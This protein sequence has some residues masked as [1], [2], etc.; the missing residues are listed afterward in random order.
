MGGQRIQLREVGQR[1]YPE[2][3][4]E[5]VEPAL[6]EETA[7]HPG[8]AGLLHGPCELEPCQKGGGIGCSAFWVAVILPRL[9]R[10]VV[11]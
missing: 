7:L 2:G 4:L 3:G 5:V 11:H 10:S 8:S 1:R 9:R 6:D